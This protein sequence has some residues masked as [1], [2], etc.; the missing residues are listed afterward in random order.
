MRLWNKIPIPPF[1]AR[2]NVYH[3]CN[4][5]NGYWDIGCYIVFYFLFLHSKADTVILVTEL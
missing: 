4:G 2:S 5:D 1:G 3:P